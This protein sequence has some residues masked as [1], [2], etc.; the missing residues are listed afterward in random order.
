MEEQEGLRQPGTIGD[1]SVRDLLADD[2]HVLSIDYPATRGPK[3]MAAARLLPKQRVA[4]YIFSLKPV[5][6]R[7]FSVTTRSTRSP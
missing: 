4:F 2:S 5:P 1:T 6:G 3:A 7:R